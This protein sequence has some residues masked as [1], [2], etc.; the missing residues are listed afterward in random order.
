[1]SDNPE[2]WTFSESSKKERARLIAL[3][4]E[5]Q[6]YRALVERQEHEFAEYRRK[7]QIDQARREADLRREMDER[8]SLFVRREQKLME[9]QRDFESRVLLREQDTEQLQARLQAEIADRERA[10]NEAMSALE[11]EK[12]RYDA[13]SREKL[14]RTSRD[15]VVDALE[16][17]AS[18]E[19]Q[20]QTLATRWSVMGAISLAA[21][22]LIFTNLSRTTNTLP[23]EA[24]TWE[25]IAFSA[26]KGLF[27]VALLA[28]LAKYAFI[29][30]RSYMR[31]SLKNADRRHAIN[32]GKFY[33][34]SYGASADWA[35]V[36]DAFEH[37]NIAAA[38]TFG[39]SEGSDPT[40]MSMLEKA[41]AILEQTRDAEKRK[42]A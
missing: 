42:A 19:S 7:S 15:Y 18:K 2:E 8:E 35:Q 20:F 11:R 13:A 36:K 22:V 39:G 30:S 1:M 16:L 41:M 9:R 26:F 31:E 34:E 10:L 17:L 4:G 33:L 40:S 27:A 12:E 21:A 32:F 37:W 28:G 25:F 38:S 29:F 6:E 5:L 23:T 3:Q 24:I 14:E